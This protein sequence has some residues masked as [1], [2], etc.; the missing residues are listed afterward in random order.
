MHTF[1]FFFFAVDTEQFENLPIF[2][3]IKLYCKRINR[4]INTF[5]YLEAV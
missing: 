3:Y 2:F 4:H 5:F 1:H